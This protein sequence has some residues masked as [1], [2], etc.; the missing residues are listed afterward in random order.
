M[1]HL[2]KSKNLEILVDL[3]NEG[4]QGARFDWCGKITAIRYQ[5]LALTTFERLDAKEHSHFGKV[6]YNEFGI[7]SPLGFKE[8]ALGDWFH[9]IG[10]GLL[11]KE[12]ES[13]GFA[14]NFE[15][16]PCEFNTLKTQTAIMVRCLAPSYNDFGYLLSKEIRLVE[17]GFEIAYQLQNSGKMPIITDEYCHN[18]LAVDS[19]PLDE[20]Y[21]LEFPVPLN[22]AGFDEAVNPGQTVW[23][24]AKTL[25]LTSSLKNEI[26][27]S[28]ITQSKETLAEWQLYHKK[29][30]VGIQ[31]LGSFT[32]NKINIW[33]CPHTISP[34]LFFK[35]ALAPG[36]TIAWSRRYSFWRG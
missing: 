18:F 30:R 5:G 11:R 36:E 3:P 24:N 21:S 15:I 2:L 7:D 31:E 13:Y 23:F 9:K 28:N 6:M 34:E 12:K 25:R 27:F 4:Y 10:I 29:H 20:Q 1:P 16:K 26:F 14:D 17:H 8:A 35:I 19:H 32:T 22:V 33:G